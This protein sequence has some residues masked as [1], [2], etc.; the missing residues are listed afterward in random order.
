MGLNISVF[1]C[2]TDSSADLSQWTSVPGGDIDTLV[3]C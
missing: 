3:I 2:Y 1:V